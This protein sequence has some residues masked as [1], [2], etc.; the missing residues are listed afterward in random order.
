MTIPD[1][2]ART[3]PPAAALH[4]RLRTA[5]ELLESIADMA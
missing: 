4:D 1:V 2:I 5:A 3:A